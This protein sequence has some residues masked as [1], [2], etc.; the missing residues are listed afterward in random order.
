MN[1]TNAATDALQSER[2]V[3]LDAYRGFVMLMM[4]SAGLGFSDMAHRF[5]DS[6]YWRF[7]AYEFSHVEWVGCALWDL[8][9]P[10][11]M[12][13]VGVSMPFSYARRERAG[14]SFRRR[15]GHAVYRSVVL[16]ALGVFLYS[17]GQ[18]QTNFIFP[19][20]LAQIGLGYAWVFFTLGRPL[21]VQLGVASAI[22]VGYWAL[23]FLYPP[24]AADFDFARVNAGPE[25]VL[26]GIFAH[27][28]K[29]AN[30]ASDFDVWFLNLFPRAKRFEFNGGGYQ[31]LNFVPSMAT[32]IFGVI[33]GELLRGERTP[34][35]KLTLL[36][37]G[38]A[39]L[40]VLGTIAGTTVCPIVKRIWTPSWALLSGGWV[41]WFL[42]A[43]YWLVDIRGWRRAVFP[44]VVVGMNSI[45]IYLMDSLLRGW[46][47]GSIGTHLGPVGRRWLFEG[48]CGP[49]FEHLALLG[50]FWLI[51]YWMYRQR[52]FVRI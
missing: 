37:A 39:V 22:L 23:F 21:G 10:A 18:S 36:L 38:G 35:R 4:A 47:L 12:F 16:T 14:D 17:N 40:L 9:Q 46:L 30:L 19:N 5:P 13:M 52:I 26:D 51:C 25:A 50:A 24:P 3:A 20:V 28:S 7:L 2:L 43:F 34:E 33:A 6:P 29:N 45:A 31:T 32:M 27:W 1:Q 11:F 41:V 15:L 8:I 48:T 42:A 49:L 44:L